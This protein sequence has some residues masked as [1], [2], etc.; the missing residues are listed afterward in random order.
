MSTSLIAPIV[1]HRPAPFR[2]R[3]AV[4]DENDVSIHRGPTERTRASVESGAA[5]RSPSPPHRSDAAAMIRG[6]GGRTESAL[7]RELDRFFVARPDLSHADRVAIARAMSRFRNQLLHRP[8]STLR[9]AAAAD[10]A[11]AH[12]LVDA[13]RSLFKLHDTPASNRSDR[14]T[15][16]DRSADPVPKESKYQ[17]F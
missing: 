12:H 5:V 15:P 9:V 6:L 2:E 17:D 13:V 16:R 8:R 10:P 11:G 3:S 7:R 4:C 14:P 1:D